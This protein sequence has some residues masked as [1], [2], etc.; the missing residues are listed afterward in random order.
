MEVIEAIKQ[1]KSERKYL[2]KKITKEVL[3]DIIDCARLAPSACNTQPWRFIVVTDKAIKNKIAEFS[4]WGKFLS[5][6]SA[7]VLVFGK[8]YQFVVEDCSAAT[9]NILLA[10]TGHGIGSCWI[11]G[12][13][14][15][16]SADIAEIFSVPKEYELMSI[17]SL[18][19]ADTYLERSRAPKKSLEEVLS[20][21]KF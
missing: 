11:A 14:C 2:S 6:C 9:Q 1:R 17:I 5:H 13:R 7:A 4:S 20:F 12:Y 15:P 21:N 10:A 8:T 19:Y 3:N 18:G 16:Y